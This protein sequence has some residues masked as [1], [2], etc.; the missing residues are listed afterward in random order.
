MNKSNWNPIRKGKTYCSSA[1]G[2]GCTMAD[3]KTA[4]ARGKR[5]LARMKG[6]GWKLHVNENIGWFYCVYNS[7]VTV[8]P[9]YGASNIKQYPDESKLTYSCLISDEVG[10]AH[11]GLAM[12]GDNF[13]SKN[14]NKAVAHELANVRLVVGKLFAALV[15]AAKAAGETAL[16]T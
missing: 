13:T 2:G 8:S 9:N 3:Y 12:W 14:P 1:C 15:S 6:K 4:L 16:K 10:K 5:L 7:N 11:S